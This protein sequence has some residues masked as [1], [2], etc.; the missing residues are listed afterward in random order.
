M[1]ETV[2]G[3]DVYLALGAVIDTLDEKDVPAAIRVTHAREAIRRI[4]NQIVPDSAGAAGSGED[5]LSRTALLFAALISADA[6][7]GQAARDVLP[8]RTGN[9]TYRQHIENWLRRAS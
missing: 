4:R 1:A 7:L 5:S 9:I 8:P 2:T 3:M 6:L